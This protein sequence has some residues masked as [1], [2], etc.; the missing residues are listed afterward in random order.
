MPV[1]IRARAAPID[2]PMTSIPS[3]IALRS[4]PG[5]PIGLMAPP[6]P[7]EIGAAFDRSVAL[8]LGVNTYA[9]GLPSLQ[10]P[11][12]DAE[13]VGALLAEDHHFTQVLLR[14][15]EVTRDRLRALL[16]SK[17]REPLGR[18]L[19]E[20]DRLLLYFAG[21]GL[22]VPS[23]HGPEGYLL[24]ADAQPGDPATFFS[25]AEL[26][27]LISAL[28]CRHV[29]IVLDCCFAGTFR[30]ASKSANR[31]VGGP[32]YRETFDRFVAQRAW[33][34]LVSASHDQTAHDA[35]GAPPLRS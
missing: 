4:V 32:I 14:N 26:R 15:G 27:K 12:S 19:G 5:H 35:S 20:R 31:D 2:T 17:L 18:P 16:D 29:L 1:V 8:V 33:Q 3:D 28:H 21:H 24:L 22:S 34:V 9:H 7:P 11:V 6:G 30:W 10:T 25:M 13:A 23:Q